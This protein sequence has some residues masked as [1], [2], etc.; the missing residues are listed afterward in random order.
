MP[1]HLA[2]DL[3]HA[4]RRCPFSPSFSSPDEFRALIE[5][6]LPSY[7]RATALCEAYLG[8]LSWFITMIE[9]TQITQELLPVIY[10]RKIKLA[11]DGTELRPDA[12]D[13]A[14]LLIVF[15]CGAAGDLTQPPDNQEGLEYFHLARAALGLRSVFASASLVTVQTMILM[16]LYDFFSFRRSNMEEAWKLISFAS[17]I[18]TSVSRRN[19]LIVYMILIM[20]S[21]YS[22]D[23]ST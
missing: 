19:A 22:S 20:T 4:S 9:R 14:L 12:H 8:N 5:S 21:K 3:A 18:A 10:K 15:A 2:P 13:L 23:R 16:G 17:G 6:H 7:E 11:P 1:H